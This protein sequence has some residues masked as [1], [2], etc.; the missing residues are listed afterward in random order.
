MM[1]RCPEDDGGSRVQEFRFDAHKYGRTAN[2]VLQDVLDNISGDAR[3]C[4]HASGS[5]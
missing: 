3:C 5:T 4:D 1:A 2:W